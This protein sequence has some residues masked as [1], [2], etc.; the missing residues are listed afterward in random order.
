MLRVPYVTLS[1]FFVLAAGIV[2]C[3]AG[4]SSASP[5]PAQ[6]G[7]VAAPDGA[8][9]FCCPARTG[10]CALSGGYR[11]SGTCP[12]NFDI[13]DNMC[14]QQIVKDEHG[15]D[16]LTYKIPPVTTTFAGT[17]SCS[18]PVYN[19]GGRPDAGADADASSDASA[20]ASAE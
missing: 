6:A 4:S 8:P 17:G 10:G 18:A 3:S 11:E 15:C 5:D 19:G 9:G 16:K 13:C 14:E 20:D 12:T 1:L 2:A 7:G